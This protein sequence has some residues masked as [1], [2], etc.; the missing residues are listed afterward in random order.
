MPVV[1]IYLRYDR[2]EGDPDETKRQIANNVADAIS[3][4]LINERPESLHDPVTVAFHDLGPDYY[5]VE[6]MGGGIEASPPENDQE[7]GK[8]ED[9]GRR[10]LQSASTTLGT[11]GET[12]TRQVPTVIKEAKARV[13]ELS[14]ATVS[15][16]EQVGS[17]IYDRLREPLGSLNE[18]I[19][20][21][22]R[23]LNRNTARLQDDPFEW[24]KTTAASVSATFLTVENMVPSFSDLA[25]TVKYKFA[26][27][28][29][30][31]AWRPIE[32]A[33]AFFEEGVPAAVRNLGEDAV[34]KF[35][36]GKHASHI[37]AVANAPEMMTEHANI[38]WES[39]KDNLAR[40]AADMNP[41]ELAKA[42]ALNA[43]DATG[44]LASQAIMTA[45]TAGAIGMALEG[46]VTVAE[47]YIYVYRGEK[48]VD[49]AVK[50]SVK[51]V[52][53]KGGISA[54]GGVGWMVALSLGAGPAI[55][56]A[57]PVIVTVGSATFIVAAY[58][59]IK[60]ALDSAEE[61]VEGEGSAEPEQLSEPDLMDGRRAEPESPTGD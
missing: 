40:G 57:G 10:I 22:K 61:P 50:E 5:L 56:A 13:E 43:I 28:G 14:G 16:M 2:I 19:N 37:R 52:L 31:G 25:P 48:D 49:E 55:S 6:Y 24:C 60:T 32:V 58:K 8:L 33:Q 17:D 47:N 12:I 21:H 38:V 15:Q 41:M 23:R 7:A 54:I 20:E 36:K 45:A 53:K 35:V 9:T 11:V 29:L 3:Q 59:R 42:N 44:I 34:L 51:G 27:A 30:R 1:H 26:V 39:A 46:V 18:I 4:H